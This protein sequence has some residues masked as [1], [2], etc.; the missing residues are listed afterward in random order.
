MN[1]PNSLQNNSMGLLIIIS[2]SILFSVFGFLIQRKDGFEN[3]A[4]NCE[5]LA[6]IFYNNL[7]FSCILDL[8]FL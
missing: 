1:V 5:L 6:H 2:I 3:K 8:F 7:L 4:V